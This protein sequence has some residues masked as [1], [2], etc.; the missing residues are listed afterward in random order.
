MEKC[1]YD[2]EL[3]RY[4]DGV[5]YYDDE[6]VETWMGIDVSN[7]QGDIDWEQVADAGVEFVML[8][9]GFRGYTEGTLNMDNRFAQNAEG[10]AEAG[11]KVGVY[12]FSTATSE[13][14]AI[15]EAEFVLSAIEDYDIDYPVVYDWEANSRSY[16]NY[17]L[18]NETLTNAAI[19][20]CERVAEEGYTPMIYFNLPVGYLRYDLS[21]LTEYDFW[22]AQ[23]PQ[24]DMMYPTMYYN[25][26]M[27]QYSDS[28]SIPG[29]QGRV[30]MN[31]AWKEW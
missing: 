29:I 15:A 26:Q 1:T 16:R 3:F 24:E 2:Q 8:R 20:F 7:Y 17:N 22:L 10:A 31:I 13:E 9:V 27:W 25:F 18:D 5:L 4:E 14:E 12:I 6:D 11:L 19:A 23:Y 28:G 30:D 21:A